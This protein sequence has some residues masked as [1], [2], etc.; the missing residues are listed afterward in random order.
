MLYISKEKPDFTELF[1]PLAK[2]INDIQE[3]KMK[4]FFSGTLYSCN[5]FILLG[6]FDLPAR[7]MAS[8]LKQYS[9][10][11]SCIF[12]LHPGKQVVDQLG[13]KYIRYVRTHEEIEKRTHDDDVSAITKVK[14]NDKYGLTNTHPMILFK[15]FDLTNGFIIDYMHNIVLGIT[16]LLIDLWLGDHRVTKKKAPILPK[17]R[18]ILNQRLIKLKPCSYATRKPRSL[19][20]RGNFK[21]TEYRNL[22][23]YYLRFALNG[24]LDNNKIKHFELLSAA[25]YIQS[26]ISEKEALEASDML[27]KFADQ[28]ERIYGQAAVTMNVHILRHYG[29]SVLQCGPL[30]SYSLFAF[31]K[32]IGTL[33][34]S[35][36]NSTDALDT[37]TFDYCLMRKEAESVL[38][39]NFAKM[40]RKVELTSKEKEILVKNDVHSLA[41]GHFE[42]SDSIE[43]NNQIF[44]SKKSRCNKSIDYF[45]QL[46][47]DSFGIIQFFIKN[48]ENVLVLIELCEIVEKHHHL[49]RIKATSEYKLFNSNQIHCKLM[50]MKIGS[51]EIV[52]KEPNFFETT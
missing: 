29:S 49:I 1:Y 18:N 10:A 11:K 3:K 27:I 26:K 2:E 4:F 13:Q 16:K 14:S 5:P 23:L 37:I 9:G 24:L 42:V 40:K 41:N 35:V 48:H 6:A 12:C 43:L 17:D 39:E 28:F 51:F 47:D 19:H 8:A 15:N 22:L 7:A 32:N 52:S 36:Y 44:K 38:I 21:A 50:Y 34:K 33:K 46:R 30:W 20:E 45:V 31:E 25:T